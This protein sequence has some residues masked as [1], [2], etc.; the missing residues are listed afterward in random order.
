M[1]KVKFLIE[2]E[3][4]LQEAIEF[5]PRSLHEYFKYWMYHYFIKNAIFT[6]KV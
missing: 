4:E 6:A 5:N 1:F 3:I 2:T